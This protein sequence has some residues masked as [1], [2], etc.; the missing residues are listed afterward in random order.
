MAQPPYEKHRR[1]TYTDDVP[2]GAVRRAIRRVCN[3]TE[4]QHSDPDPAAVFLLV[5]L[6]FLGAVLEICA[7]SISGGLRILR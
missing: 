7:V 6:T 2:V 5:V 1:A 3:C 4:F